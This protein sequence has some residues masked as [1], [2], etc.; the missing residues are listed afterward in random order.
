MLCDLGSTKR[1][2]YSA[3]ELRLSI[4]SGLKRQV[5]TNMAIYQDAVPCE[6]KHYQS[7]ASVDAQPRQ[8]LVSTIIK[9]HHLPQLA[10]AVFSHCDH[11][12][13]LN[14]VLFAAK[15]KILYHVSQDLAFNFMYIII[16][17]HYY[18]IN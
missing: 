18:S 2:G 17:K 5:H 7:V 12:N 3:W 8:R 4:A 6:V 1:L 14:S 9:P 16:F 10:R 11:Y 15:V 13:L